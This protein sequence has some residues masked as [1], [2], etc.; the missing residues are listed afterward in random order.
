MIAAAEAIASLAEEGELVPSPLNLDVHRAVAGAVMLAAH[1][2][3]SPEVP[4]VMV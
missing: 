4:D 2:E 1:R 3:D